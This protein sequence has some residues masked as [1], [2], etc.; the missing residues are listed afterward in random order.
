[1]IQITRE[2]PVTM[3]R[4]G[5][6]VG[7]WVPYTACAFLLGD[8]LIDT[9]PVCV[10]RE[11][12]SALGG[13]AVKQVLFTH[14]HEDHIGNCG[15]VMGRT[16]A[17]SFAHPLA[18][19]YIEDPRKL[20]LRPYQ[21]FVWGTPPP[22]RALAIGGEIRAGDFRLRVIHTAGHCPDHLCFYEPKRRW[23]FTGDLFCGP[24][25]KYFR[26]DEDYSATV[27]ALRRLA[28]LKIDIV[29]CSLLGAVKG[30]GTAI[31]KKLEFMESL[32][33]RVMALHERGM[34][35]GRISR[36]LLG[37]EGSMRAITLGHYAKKNAVRSI[38]TGGPCVTPP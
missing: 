15:A 30:G 12:L 25:L 4:M 21:L 22:S 7:P 6:S 29:F 11:L 24:R 8:I 13:T 3:I 35:E 5:R 9:G 37:S 14:R 19:P 18:L 33:D 10:R 31:E 26:L 17:E 20:R 38:L 16:G 28:K 23:L 2:G 32:R 1:M 36:S 34:S 27:E